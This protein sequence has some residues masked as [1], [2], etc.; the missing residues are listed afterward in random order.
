MKL[1]IVI[2]VYN[3]EK[4]L[5]QC[6]DS[7]IVPEL[8][9]YE[10][11][12][13][14]DGST[15]SSPD[16]LRHYLNKYS[17]LLNVISKTNGGLG[18]ARRAGMEKASG[19]Y[20][21][22]LD[23]DDYYTDCAVAEMLEYCRQDFDICFFDF[24]SVSEDGRFLKRMKGCSSVEGEF[25]LSSYPQV[26]FDL[27]S[28]TNKIFR[29][30]LFRET[31]IFFPDRVWFEDLRTIP[32]LYA[33]ASKMIYCGRPWYYYRQQA[34]SITHGNAP[35]RNL[36]IIDA[37]EDLVG[38]FKNHNS[39][40]R[41]RA[42]IDYLVYYNELLTSIDRVNLI[43]RR[44]DIQDKLLDFF[45]ANCPDIKSNPY[46]QAVPKKFKLLNFFI[47]R[48]MWFCLNMVLRANELIHMKK[49]R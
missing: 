21:V 48:R 22:F 20:I 2:P 9:D 36:E 28:G 10:I 4:Y 43:D 27:P 37:V 45:N 14:D 47:F 24:I 42:E 33:F 46:Y 25:T 29:T 34:S 30:S 49:I 44:S 19:E 17:G 3:V 31:G 40:D 6:L 5:S 23:S 26:L 18:S 35:A 1:S 11:I 39:Y 13:V 41:Y 7:V 38:W 12:A 15:D 32:K 8:D 16:I